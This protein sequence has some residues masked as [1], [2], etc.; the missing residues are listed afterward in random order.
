VSQNGERRSGQVRGERERDP[1]GRGRDTALAACA[2]AA[3]GL[4]AYGSVGLPPPRFEPM[5][6]AA[7]PRIL[8]GLIALF[9]LVILAQ[10]WLGRGAAIGGTA[11]RAA[12]PLR[13]IG[14][15]CALL[16][17]VAALD[18]GR[19]P[20]IPAT[21]AFTLALGLL[22]TRRSP[23]AMAGFAILGLILSFGIDVV[24]SAFLYVDLG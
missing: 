4:L 22:L 8:A 12:P 21:I 2:L 17:Y 7:L 15:F 16:A 9:A 3:A 10:A 14:A 1:P 6:S 11:A 5:G 23:R 13:A 24:F 19:A 20:F 18:F